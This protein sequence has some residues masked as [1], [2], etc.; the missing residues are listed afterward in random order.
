MV[1]VLPPWLASRLPAYSPRASRAFTI[2]SDVAARSMISDF[3]FIVSGES[4][5]KPLDTRTSTRS[6]GSFDIACTTFRMEAYAPGF[7]Y[8][9]RGQRRVRLRVN[10]EIPID[11]R[12]R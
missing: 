5:R 4:A 2:T 7:R 6:R 8:P 10:P 12:L 1:D 3:I 9:G 11:Q